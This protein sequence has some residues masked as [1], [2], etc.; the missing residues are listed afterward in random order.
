MSDTISFQFL[1]DVSL[2]DHDLLI[3]VE[4]MTTYPVIDCRI[5][6]NGRFFS[7]GDIPPGKKRLKRLSRAEINKSPVFKSGTANS[8]AQKTIG[9]QPST[10][11]ENLR[12]NL[13]ES[14]LGQVHSRY[15]TNQEVFYLF[16]WIASNAIPNPFMRPGMDSEGAGLLEWETHVRPHTE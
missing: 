13:L 9:E 16:G 2:E 6:H 12:E 14:L 5:Y 7:F 8:A 15:Q 4:N 1:G 3:T 10:L 11:Y